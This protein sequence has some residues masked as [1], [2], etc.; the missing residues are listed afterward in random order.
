MIV[1]SA[2]VTRPT[3]LNK[4]KGWPPPTRKASQCGQHSSECGVVLLQAPYLQRSVC[5]LGA[6]CRFKQAVLNFMVL[7]SK[8][9]PPELVVYVDD[10]ESCP[11]CW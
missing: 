10:D 9:A 4:A 7:T 6:V 11:Q 3:A 1:R 8:R 2:K 5:I